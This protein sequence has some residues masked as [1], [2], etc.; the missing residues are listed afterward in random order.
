M[1]TR[2]R[3]A[4]PAKINLWLRVFGRDARGYHAIES[5]FQLLTLHDELEVEATGSG[6][7]LSG[8]PAALGDASHNLAVRA[9][10]RFF[11]QTGVQGGAAISLTKRIPWQAGLGGGSSDAAATLRALNHIYGRPLEE[12]DLLT[13]G[14]ELGS[15]VPFFLSGAALALGWGRGERLLALAPLPSLPALIVPPAAPVATADAYAWLDQMRGSETTGEYA[16]ALPAA[17][18]TSWAQV[19]R[20]SSNDFEPAV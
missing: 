20:H 12:E 7:T 5:L 6:V 2:V 1:S 11:R 8:A 10:L 9:A 4:A 13:L 16:A 18:L 15:D 17:A 14:A 19:K 3:I